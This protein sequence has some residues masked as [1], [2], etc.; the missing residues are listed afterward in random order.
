MTR[1]DGFTLVEL[2]VAM[3]VGAMLLVALSWSIASLGRELTATRTVAAG[4]DVQ[5]VTPALTALIEASQPV[6][7]GGQPIVNRPDRYETITSSPAALGPV[8][9]IRM[10]LTA[11]RL[12]DGMALEIATAPADPSVRLPAIVTA[13]RALVRGMADIRFDYRPADKPE[14]PP[15]LVTIRMTDTRGMAHRIA[16]ATKLNG[17]AACRFDP[18]SMTCRP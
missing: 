1:D 3:V 8:G 7:P 16:V 4:E 2:L 13:S 6:R 12:P 11:R 17:Q 10:A 5:A 15:R 14:L 9:L 18:I